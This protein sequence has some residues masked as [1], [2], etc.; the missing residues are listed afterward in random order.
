VF[1]I[2][3]CVLFLYLLGSLCFRFNIISTVRVSVFV[4]PLFLFVL[5]IIKYINFLIEIRYS[6]QL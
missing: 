2:L 1:D 3:L 5:C 4:V 6:V